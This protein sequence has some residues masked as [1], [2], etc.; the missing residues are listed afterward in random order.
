MLYHGE[1]VVLLTK[2]GKERVIKPLL[3]GETGCELVLEHRF[4]T[5]RLG[6]FSR[7]IKRRRSQ[8]NTARLKIKKALKL[9]K[10]DIGIASEGSFGMHPSGLIPWNIELVL[11]YDRKEKIEVYGVHQTSK[12]N[13][14][15]IYVDSYEDLLKFAKRIGFPEHYVILR[16][17]HKQSKKIYKDIFSEETLKDVYDRCMSVSK[18]GKVFAETDMR[19]HANPTR[20][21]SILKATEQMLL[22]LKRVCPICQ[23]PGF[24][25]IKAISGLACESCDMPT[26]L[27]AKTLYQCQKCKHEKE[28]TSPY[29]LRAPS[30]Y[31]HNCNP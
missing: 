26:E 3:E 30:M 25:A 6:T 10:L 9:S 4:D 5:D 8:M 21:Q 31:C 22:N 7:Q 13:F 23:A 1:K 29:G 27:T 24:M 18:T 15:D 14:S 17:D 28:S 20:M 2:H 12:T 19:A 16:P 11:L